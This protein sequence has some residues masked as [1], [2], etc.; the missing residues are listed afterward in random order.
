M[1]DQVSPSEPIDEGK[2]ASSA[3]VG[4]ISHVSGGQV[5]IAGRDI[6]QAIFTGETKIEIE[7]IIYR[8]SDIEKLLQFIKLAVAAFRNG[9]EDVYIR[10][11]PK[12]PYKSL[13]AFEMADHSI[14]FGRGKA[15]DELCQKVVGNKLT[16][17]HAPSGAGKTSL[18]NAGLSPHLYKEGY[19]PVYNSQYTDFARSIKQYLTA[20]CDWPRPELFDKLNLE[21]VIR[22]VTSQSPRLKGMV[23]FLDQFENYWG[24][25]PHQRP[26]PHLPEKLENCLHITNTSVHFVISIRDDSFS[27]LRFLGSAIPTIFHNEYFLEVMSGNEVKE[28][29]EKPLLKLSA[30]IQFEPTLVEE[31]SK[32]TESGRMALPQLQII[33]NHLYEQALKSGDN[34]ILLQSYR[35]K[36]GALAILGKYLEEK[37]AQFGA[38]QKLAKSILQEMVSTDGEKQAYTPE[39]LSQQLHV[40]SQTIEHVL[41]SLLNHRLLQCDEQD[42]LQYFRIVHD[43]LSQRIKEWMAPELL[44]RKS[45]LELLRRKV[46]DWQQ[47]EKRHMSPETFRGLHPRLENLGITDKDSIDCL[48][49]SAFYAASPLGPDSEFQI[50]PED[51]KKVRHWIIHALQSGLEIAQLL[52]RVTTDPCFK[53]RARNINILGQLAIPDSRQWIEKALQDEYPQVRI[54]AI[55]SLEKL[56]PSGAWRKDLA[57]ERLVPGGSFLM[58]DD[59]SDENFDKPFGF[60][61][62]PGFYI[63]AHPVTNAEYQRYDPDHKYPPELDNHP[64]VGKTWIETNAYARWAGKRLLSE[65]EWEKAASWDSAKS[66]KRRFPWGD[67]FDPLRCNT[68]EGGQNGT[69]P[70]G[71]YSPEGDSPYGCSDM[72]GNV[73][74][75]TSSLFQGYPYEGDESFESPE[76]SYCRVLRGGCHSLGQAFATCTYRK[77]GPAEEN[78]SNRL[79]GFRL[80]LDENR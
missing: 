5:N 76:R 30:G 51:V 69:T 59:N 18:L 38:E 44:E 65:A 42:G 4:S 29:I 45:A 61:E 43:Y 35:Q 73:W 13:S 34:R 25:L 46:L 32:D 3:S 48:I 14:F 75:W 16:V 55:R 60:C 11:E 9:L 22:G 53:R 47:T 70:V 27:R 79:I 20:Y 52:E 54:Q 64:V 26:D 36:G 77:A 19:L 8:E 21:E 80:G 31:L 41:Q 78:G 23:I 7:N 10:Q 17:L 24:L 74:E 66:H 56:H 28:A 57:F 49:V 67:A 58:G 71:R 40:D 12:T 33:C 50:G 6:F 1:S 37:L 2:V 68:L 15:I 63:D 62:V 39:E 72:A